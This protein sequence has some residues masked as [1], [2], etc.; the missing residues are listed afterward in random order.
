MW[1]A[2]AATLAVLLSL[3]GNMASNTVALSVGWAAVLW[4]I[5]GLMGAA[6]V[7]VAVR[8][9]RIDQRDFP[10]AAVVSG[11]GSTEWLAGRVLFL[12]EGRL[13]RVSEVSLLQLRVKPAIETR[14]ADGADQPPY[15][16]RDIDEDLEW[17]IAAGGLVLLH[18]RAAVGKSRAAAEALRRL[19]P[20]QSMVVPVA[21]RALRELVKSGYDLGDA[22]VWLDDLEQFLT[23]KAWISLCC[24]NCAQQSRIG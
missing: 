11:V 9:H 19:R 8:Q 16:P 13:P 7:A 20:E 2:T 6:A 1:V 24:N 15:V 3:I 21:G 23:P 22:V 12:V 14:R 17:A 5:V 10:A 18:G 4:V